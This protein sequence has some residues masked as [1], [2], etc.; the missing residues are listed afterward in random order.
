MSVP[1]PSDIPKSVPETD[2][3]PLSDAHCEGSPRA[4]SDRVKRHNEDKARV[5]LQK[6]A[7][8]YLARR[9][10][11]NMLEA[12]VVGDDDDSIHLDI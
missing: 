7:K 12:M 3:I 4:E 1:E 9:R 8:G 11:R 2:D 10:F 5:H 6:L